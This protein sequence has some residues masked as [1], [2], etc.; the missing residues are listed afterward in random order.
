MCDQFDQ[1]DNE[2]A[3]LS[4]FSAYLDICVLDRCK[5]YNI[6]RERKFSISVNR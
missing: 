4:F 1:K 3:Y 2:V 6:L 5:I